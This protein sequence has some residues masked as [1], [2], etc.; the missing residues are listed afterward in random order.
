MSKVA[1]PVYFNKSAYVALSCLI[2]FVI[3]ITICIIKQ[4][5]WD[6][7]LSQRFEILRPVLSESVRKLSSSFHRL[8]STRTSIVSLHRS[9]SEACVK[10]ADLPLNP[11]KTLVTVTHIVY[12]PMIINMIHSIKIF[13]IDHMVH[14]H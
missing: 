3:V 9:L 13:H 4:F 10:P 6:P 7:L 11:S 8:Q 1:E 5:I 2:A 14:H 12:Q